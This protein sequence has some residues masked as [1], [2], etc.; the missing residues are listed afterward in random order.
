MQNV[1]DMLESGKTVDEVRDIQLKKKAP[2][3]K[4]VPIKKAA[5]VVKKAPAKPKA[6]EEAALSDAEVDKQAAEILNEI[7]AASSEIKEVENENLVQLD[8]RMTPEDEMALGYLVQQ[9]PSDY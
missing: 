8:S 7:K 4:V 2:A 3:K 6:A 9:F 5:T 1:I